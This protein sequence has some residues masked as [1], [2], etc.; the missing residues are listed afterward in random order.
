[1]TF[2]SSYKGTT[3]IGSGAHPLQQALILTS[4]QRPY[5]PTQFTGRDSVSFS[6][7][8]LVMSDSL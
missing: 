7:S 1:M 3:Y 2:S 6:V 8:Q 5:F 4:L